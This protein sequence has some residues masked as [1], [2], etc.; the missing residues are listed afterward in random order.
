MLQLRGGDAL[1]AEARGG[2][3]GE[4]VRMMVRLD[5]IEHAVEGAEGEERGD[6]AVQGLGVVDVDRPVTRGERQELGAAVPPPLP[7]RPLLRLGLARIAAAVE[8]IR[9]GRP[10]DR[11]LG[12]V[13]EEEAV[14]LAH[15]P[16]LLIL[17]DEEGEV[18][19]ARRLR[20]Q[21]DLHLVEHFEHRREIV[22]DGADA[23]SH[24]RDGRGGRDQPRL[25]VLGE[26][27]E[28]PA[29]Q[30][31][32]QRVGPG[33]QGDGDVGLRGRDRIDRQAVAGEDGEDGGEEADLMPH[34]QGLHGDQ[35]DAAAGGD[36]LHLRTALRAGDR[37][38]GAGD[39]RPLGA[40]D[41]EWDAVGAQRRDGARM[42]D[43]GAGGGD[44]LGLFVVESA[45]QAGGGRRAG[46]AVNMPGTSV[47]I[48]HRS[49]P[50]RAAKRAAEVSEPPRPRRTVSPAALRAMNPWVIR[51]AAGSAPRRSRRA[52]SRSK[53]QEAAR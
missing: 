36:R 25:A 28:K 17:V 32:L 35:G 27:A 22:E 20:H 48:S 6:G 18:E 23:S 1:E 51:T 13:T 8:Q 16:L 52:S 33:V 34:P 29:E 14:K 44:L 26:V 7:R 38:H 50:R 2:E 10:E 9:P 43:L 21:M 30:L 53:L 4:D 39:L 41:A 42:E 11:A 3:A 49:A 47:Q 19:I 12:L 40:Q 37:D 15:Q 31:G 24:Q 45:Q 5:R 46:L